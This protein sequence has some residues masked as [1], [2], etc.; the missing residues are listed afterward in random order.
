MEQ[1]A[2]QKLFEQLG[3]RFATRPGGYT[4]IQRTKQ[5]TND[6]SSM[7]YVSYLS[8]H[9]PTPVQR[10]RLSRRRSLRR[11]SS[12]VGVGCARKQALLRRKLIETRQ[13]PSRGSATPDE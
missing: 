10:V 13:L 11:S 6:N 1:P 8:A 9:E 2:V 12:V 5:R 7:A 3:P 4:R